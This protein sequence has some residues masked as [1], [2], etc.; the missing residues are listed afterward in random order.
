MGLSKRR[1]YSAEFK[2]RVALEAIKGDLTLSE[3]SS[4]YGVHQTMISKWKSVALD[5][6]LATFSG[7]QQQKTDPAKE[8]KELHA[9]IGELTMERGFFAISLQSLQIGKRSLKS[10][11]KSDIN[12]AIRR[13]C[14]LLGVSSTLY[15]YKPVVKSYN[16]ELSRLIDEQFMK[17][18]FYG[19]ERMCEHLRRCGHIVNVK[20]IR[21][22]MR[23]MGIT[24]IYQ[25]KRTTIADV[26]HVKYP[27]LLRGASI[28][29]VNQVW[30]A[31]IT[32]IP[33]GSGHMYLVAVMDWYSRCVLSWRVSNTLD[34]RFCVEALEEALLL[35]G[36]PEI[37]NAD[38]G[39]Q[40]TGKAFTGRLLAEGVQISMDGKGRWMDNVMIERL[41]RTVKYEYIYLHAFS[42]GKELKKGLIQWFDFY[43]KERI[44]A[45]LDY[46]TPYEV[47]SEANIQNSIA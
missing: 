14:A 11:I 30:C 18:P 12:L 42:G 31:D 6:L 43:N 41:W 26:G 47:Y 35:Y 38:Q 1:V 7:D 24:A 36:K 13:Q 23:E 46:N 10:L 19:V 27:Y 8:M 32:Y 25:P 2:S 17:T 20:R 40:F 44:H 15:Y 39:C 34:E 28:D 22:L 16:V 37:F 33:M 45:S 29:R 21:K 5:G 4:K 9:K 3:L